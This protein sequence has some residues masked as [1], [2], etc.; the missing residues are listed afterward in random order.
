MFVFVFSSDSLLDRGKVKEMALAA[1]LYAAVYR[2]VMS[3]SVGNSVSR[4]QP[5]H[6]TPLSACRVAR[7]I[8]PTLSG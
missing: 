5:Q 7:G 4:V 2:L 1:L 6:C 8:E 3:T